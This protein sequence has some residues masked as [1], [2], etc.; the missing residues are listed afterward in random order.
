LKHD[1]RFSAN[2]AKSKQGFRKKW[3]V[4]QTFPKSN[5]L[6]RRYLSGDY[7]DQ[8]REVMTKF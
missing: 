2:V 7:F 6:S 3:S 5:L 8:E 4:N 1:C